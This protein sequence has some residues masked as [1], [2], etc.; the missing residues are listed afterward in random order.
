MQKL[1]VNTNNDKFCKL[2]KLMNLFEIN[3]DGK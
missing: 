3:V 1:L 2:I